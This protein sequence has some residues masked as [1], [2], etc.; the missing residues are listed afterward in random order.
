[1]DALEQ[2]AAEITEIRAMGFGIPARWEELAQTAL[3]ECRAQWLSEQ[4]FRGRTGSCAKWCRE[5]F[6][7]CRDEGLARLNGSKREWHVHARRPKRN[8]RGADAIER[9]IVDSFKGAA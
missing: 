7:A 6:E 9:E 2:L 5:H 1:V 8:G 3:A 4:A